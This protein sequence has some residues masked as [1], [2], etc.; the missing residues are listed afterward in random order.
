[1]PVAAREDETGE[2]LT[3]RKVH[4]GVGDASRVAGFWIPIFS[5]YLVA[6][7]G[8]PWNRREVVYPKNTTAASSH[9]PEN[10]T[11]I[12]CR[13]RRRGEGVEALSYSFPF[14]LSISLFL[15][16]SLRRLRTYPGPLKSRP[17]TSLLNSDRVLFL[18]FFR[19]A[20]STC[21]PLAPGV[22]KRK[23]RAVLIYR[24]N[25]AY[26]DTLRDDTRYTRAFSP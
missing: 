19:H 17:P 26:P 5:A 16:S 13:G 11:A 3:L 9:Q 22:G 21:R 18:F 24:R 4:Q 7:R 6:P 2:R 12:P 20:E 1:M 25:R 8:W 14:S 23:G 10:S 15:P